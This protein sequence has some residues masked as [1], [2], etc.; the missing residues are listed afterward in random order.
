T[1][2]PEEALLG[3]CKLE[4]YVRHHPSKFTKLATLLFIYRFLHGTVSGTVFIRH[5]NPGTEN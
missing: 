5:W 2:T 1:G 3:N 4:P